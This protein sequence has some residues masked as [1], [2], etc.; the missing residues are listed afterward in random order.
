M[1]V[2]PRPSFERRVM[3]PIHSHRFW[4][5]PSVFTRVCVFSDVVKFST[6]LAFLIFLAFYCGFHNFILPISLLCHPYLMFIVSCHSC[7]PYLTCERYDPGR[8]DLWYTAVFCLNNSSSRA[9]P[10]VC[11]FVCTYSDKTVNEQSPQYPVFESVPVIA[12]DLEFYFCA[13]LEI[14][15]LVYIVFRT[16]GSFFS[17]FPMRWKRF[18]V[19]PRGV[20]HM[21]K[22]VMPEHK[23]YPP[24]PGPSAEPHIRTWD[25]VVLAYILVFLT[26]FLLGLP[27]VNNWWLCALLYISGTLSVLRWRFSADLQTPV[28]IFFFGS[29][30]VALFSMLIPI[31]MKLTHCE[32]DF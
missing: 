5:P 6:H 17:G 19:L 15:A 30:I 32:A 8:G 12:L 11:D 18:S 14:M 22:I 29:L 7:G 26:C 1:L 16:C 9:T 27:F 3:F 10:S 23:I 25:V 31:A 21:Q 13:L 28:G 4:S 2:C 24:F 20:H